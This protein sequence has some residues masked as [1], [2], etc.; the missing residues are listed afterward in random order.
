MDANEQLID[1]LY[2]ERTELAGAYIAAAQA[3]R[4]ADADDAQAEIERL[5]ATLRELGED[6]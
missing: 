2:N 3:G 4:V 1:S 5:S 6:L